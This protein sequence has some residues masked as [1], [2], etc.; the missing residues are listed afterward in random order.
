MLLHRHRTARHNRTKFIGLDTRLCRACWKC[1]EVCQKKAL[2]KIDLPFHRHAAIRNADNCKGCRK[3]AA[4]C[5]QGAITFLSAGMGS[6]DC[7]IAIIPIEYTGMFRKFDRSH[8][9]DPL[10]GIRQKTLVYGEKTLTAE[11]LLAKDSILPDHS[12][13]NEQTGYLVSGHM[14]LK[15]GSEVF[16]THAGDS[17]CI[18]MDVVHGA[19]VLEDSVAVEVFSPVRPDYLP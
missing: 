6:P 8:Y 11:F 16:E 14:R 7:P 9:K 3:C 5:P 10:P 15:I 4:A 2:G 12:H 1:I 13:P 19:Q 17:W 18:P